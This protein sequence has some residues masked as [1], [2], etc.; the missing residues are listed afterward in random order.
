NPLQRAETARTQL[1]HLERDL[2]A[3]GERLERLLAARA[4][5]E[6][7]VPQQ[8]LQAAELET[9]RLADALEAARDEHEAAESEVARLRAVRGE[10]ETGLADARQ[11]LAGARGRLSSLQAL[12]QAT[13]REDDEILRQW[14]AQQGWDDAVPAARA[15]R[16]AD[17]WEIAAEA[18]LGDYLRALCVNDFEQRTRTVAQWPAPGMTVLAGDGEDRAGMGGGGP[19]GTR[20]LATVLS[21]PPALR[22]LARDVFLVPDEAAARAHVQQLEPGQML[23]TRSGQCFGPGWL[24]MPGQDQPQASVLAREQAIAR[25]QAEVDTMTAGERDHGEEVESLRERQA[26][27]ESRRRDLATKQ[28]GLRQRHGERLAE[29]RG[30]SVRVE[31]AGRRRRELDGEIE[32]LDRR[33]RQL[34]TEVVEARSVLQQGADAAR[35]FVQRRQALQEELT[36]ARERR[37]AARRAADETRERE[38]ALQV[39]LAGKRSAWEAAGRRME[40]LRSEHQ[41]SEQRL[42]ELRLQAEQAATP[43]VAQ[44]HAK[45]EAE[46]RRD[47]ARQALEAARDQLEQIEAQAAEI[48]RLVQS[49][50]EAVEQAQDGF[51]QARVAVE[52][53]AVRR[54]TLEEQLAEA[55]YT[56]QGLAD[57]LA[58]DA[59]PATWEE[60]I[61]TLQRRIQRLGAINLAAIDEFEDEKQR[62]DYLQGQHDDLSQALTTLEAA[63]ARIDRET[64]SRFRA[65]FDEVDKRFC[66]LFPQLFGGGEARLELTEDDLLATGVRVMARPPGKRN[67]S[68]QLLSGG[69]KA[70]TA[71]ALLF[72]LFELNPAPFCML[73]EIDAPL[74]DANV[75]RFCDLV[76]HMAE[77][78][79][80]IVITHNKLTMEMV[81]RL[82]GVTMMEP[83]V[84]RLVSVDIEQALEMAS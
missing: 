54:Q 25:L 22:A 59:T 21:A 44:A 53:A 51:Q 61:E 16:V 1:V 28:D 40:Q 2:A 17:G 68:I 79:Q 52:T 13:L 14:L 58:A 5:V 49:A 29:R 7:E 56:A 12:Q 3:T 45:S 60:R 42:E 39:D 19:R 30:L 75:A 83:G 8:A 23:V 69:E 37:Q 38:Q 77:R 4:R 43:Q 76:A 71:V 18:A 48:S 31:Q 78:V 67:A 46:A 26:S 24:R 73:D 81:Q 34:E 74:D 35:E 66:A 70:L 33:R 63:I 20:S 82:H 47:A 10:A 41:R 6:D 55:G 15:V 36:A 9:G 57:E 32:E 27:A 72:A 65:T 50:E 84:S 62:E 80:F 64:R 11:A